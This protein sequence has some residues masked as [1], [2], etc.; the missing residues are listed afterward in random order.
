M[1]IRRPKPFLAS[2]A[3][4]LF[5]LAFSQGATAAEAILVGV[6]PTSFTL[7]GSVSG[8]PE[9]L[10]GLG[11]AVGFEHYLPQYS[12]GLAAS[13][14]ILPNANL[15][16][17]FYKQY[18]VGGFQ[19][20]SAATDPAQVDRKSSPLVG[21][22]RHYGIFV[23]AG[24]LLYQQSNAYEATSGLGVEFAVGV[25]FPLFPFLFTSFKS[26]FF[27]SL[28]GPANTLFLHAQLGVPFSF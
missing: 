6:S 22:Q 23:E 18:A 15:I 7:P 20:G 16:G 25:E 27:T 21:N 3:L 17:V 12:A 14:H 1:R 9:A 13:V 26:S 24:P 8:S 2:A 28:G 19:E 11:Y 4:A 5:L 10:K